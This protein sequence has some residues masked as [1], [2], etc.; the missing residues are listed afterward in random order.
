MNVCEKC[1]LWGQAIGPVS[2]ERA[3]YHPI[4]NHVRDP[5]P[6]YKAAKRR[7]LRHLSPLLIGISVIYKKTDKGVAFGP[8]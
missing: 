4:L 1:G 5:K 3:K 6:A 2:P 7:I 8:S